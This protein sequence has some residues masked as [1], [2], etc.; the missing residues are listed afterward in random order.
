MEQNPKSDAQFITDCNWYQVKGESKA[1]FLTVFTEE[2]AGEGKRCDRSN[3]NV[4]GVLYTDIYTVWPRDTVQMTGKVAVYK[5]WAAS[6]DGYTIPFQYSVEADGYMVK[7]G[8]FDGWILGKEEVTV[9]LKGARELKFHIKNGDSSD[10]HGNPV[11]TP[12]AIFLGFAELERED[13]SVIRL[14]ELDYQ[15]ENIDNGF[16]EGRDYQNGRVVIE[17]EEYPYA[18][19][20]SPV[21]HEKEGCI[22]VHTEGK[23]IRFHFCIGVDAFP[24][25]ESND[26]ITYSIQTKGKKVHYITVLEPY[27]KSSVIA[28]VEGICETAVRI[29]RQDGGVEEIELICNGTEYGVEYRERTKEGRNV[30]ER[31]KECGEEIKKKV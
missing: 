11:T 28:K 20:C 23:F 12:Q 18:M 26:R 6:G 5:G 3:Y 15:T 14:S 1:S 21:N 29:Y 8:G 16:G 2:D 24:G 27:E 10:E 4:P 31:T 7:S 19:P 22:T 25:D 9:D 13:G 17:G 30:K